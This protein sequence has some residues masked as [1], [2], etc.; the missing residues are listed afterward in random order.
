VLPAPLNLILSVSGTHILGLRRLTTR[1]VKLN[2][3][4]CRTVSCSRE[5]TKTEVSGAKMS[6]CV[7]E[8]LTC[9]GTKNC[10]CGIYVLDN[11]RD[12]VL[13]SLLPSHS[14]CVGCLPH[15]SSGVHKL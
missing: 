4:L 3:V 13:S 10:M 11:Q 15:P 1:W 5:R 7:Y 8:S 6:N 2:L 12:A 14:T 9:K